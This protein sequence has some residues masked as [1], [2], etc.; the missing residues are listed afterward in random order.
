MTDKNEMTINNEKKF[1]PNVAAIVLS[2]KYPH[3]AK[4]L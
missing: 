4:Y 2:A 1:R 3:N